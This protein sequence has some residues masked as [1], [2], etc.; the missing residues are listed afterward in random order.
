MSIK[1]KKLMFQTKTTISSPLK[2]FP[3]ESLNKAL[4]LL[5]YGVCVAKHYKSMKFFHNCIFYILEDDFDYLQWLSKL[6]PYN[7]TRIDLKTIKN[8]TDDTNFDSAL[9]KKVKKSKNT[10]RF[11]YISYGDLNENKLLILK[12]SNEQTKKLFWQGL[13][14]LSRKS[15]QKT[16]QFND[17]RRVIAQKL[18]IKADKDGSKTLDFDEIKKILQILHIEINH[19]YLVRI[20]D[21]YDKDKNKMIDWVEFQAM[22]NDICLKNELK[23]VFKRYCTEA[24]TIDENDEKFNEITMDYTEFQE[25]LKKEQKQELTQQ[26]F[27]KLL[28]LIHADATMMLMEET[29]NELSEIEISSKNLQK[30]T[31]LTFS[32]FCSIIFSKNN[33][34]FDPEKQE[35]YQDM[36]HPLSD[37]YINSSHNT[38]LLAN[39]LTGESSTKAYINA[40]AKGCRCVELDCWE[41]DKGEPIIYHGYTFTSKIMFR[42][43]MQTIKDYA[44]A[45]N[46]WPV[47]L[48]FENHCKVKQQEKMAEI[49]NEILGKSM[50]V[51]PENY[52]EYETL[53]SPY[54][55][56]YKVL[57]KDKAKLMGFIK[58]DQWEVI[59]RRQTHECEDDERYIISKETNLGSIQ[60]SS[61][62]MSS[63]RRFISSNNILK[64][65][66]NNNNISSNSLLFSSSKQNVHFIYN[67]SISSN[68]VVFPGGDPIHHKSIENGSN[69][70]A[71]TNK[72][73]YIMNESLN[74]EGIPEKSV[75]EKCMSLQL[76]KLLV[77]YGIKLNILASRSIFNISS[78]KETIF[79]KLVK[80]SPEA[81]QDFLRKYCIRVYPASTRV[82]SSNYDPMDGF[83]YG[84]QMVALN[85]QTPDLPLMI[86]MS[87]FQEN[88]G[89]GCG[90]LLKPECLR[91]KYLKQFNSICKILCVEV[92]SGQQLRPEN[93]EDIRD[94]VDP[95]VEVFLR[96]IPADEKENS[97]VF[98]SKVVQN[99]GFHPIFQLNCQF[100]LNCPDLAVIVFRVF[101]E[102]VAVKDMRIGWNSIAVSCL[103]TGYRIIPLLN[104]NLNEIE[105]SCLLC[106]IE[107][108]DVVVAE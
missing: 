89:S 5:I 2:S 95:Y 12:F 61:E 88:G 101:D 42:D 23:A 106:K 34:V 103:R 35:V 55:L 100:K 37:Y 17:F 83:N 14:H 21:K 3:A 31:R 69:S 32:E 10:S 81:L 97:V 36:N 27:R 47:I 71:H 62:W 24:A 78:V 75:K 54:E 15:I 65:P 40:F 94:V 72:N 92:I 43:V 84:A 41:G 63:H 30:R 99:N 45:A 7:K 44:F 9:E 56:K 49:L 48:S 76:K 20:F 18:F 28:K 13:Q 8:I 59:E 90:Y 25:F 53:P 6:K 52:M 46:P 98:K 107:F 16:G 26:D 11:L 57:I 50:Y 67:N 68:S 80:E 82:D 39:Q 77:F 108:K 93:E 33:S 19:E 70:P 91:K 38:Y 51:L 1:S 73:V 58:G 74:I 79:E 105:F 4:N 102:E 87:R 86:Y 64:N 66:S 104:S 60:M 22:I 29:Q 85:V 96:G